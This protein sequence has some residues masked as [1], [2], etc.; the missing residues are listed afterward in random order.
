MFWKYIGRALLG[1][2][3]K[4]FTAQMIVL[5]FERLVGVFQVENEGVLFQAE[6]AAWAKV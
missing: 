3:L 6:S 4:I 1:V 5:V 2:S